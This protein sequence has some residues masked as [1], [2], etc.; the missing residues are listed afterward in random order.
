MTDRVRCCVL[1]GVFSDAKSSGA[2]KKAIGAPFQ[3]LI[4]AIAARCAADGDSKIDDE[5]PMQ[6]PHAHL[7]IKFV[8]KTVRAP[9]ATALWSVIA[10]HALAH[11]AYNRGAFILTGLVEAGAPAVTKAVA[12][13]LQK[14]LPKLLTAQKSIGLELLSKKLASQ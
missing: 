12:A 2:L 10:D 8:L 14:S 3:T 9:F 7:F 13:K 5:H 1:C 6:H 4:T 11:A